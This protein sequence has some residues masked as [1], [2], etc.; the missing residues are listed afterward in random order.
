MGIRKFLIRSHPQSH[1]TVTILIAIS[2]SFS[3]LERADRHLRIFFHFLESSEPG[4]VYCALFGKKSC[5]WKITSAYHF[6]QW[7]CSH[8]FYTLVGM[9]QFNGIFSEVARSQFWHFFNRGRRSLLSSSVEREMKKI[10]HLFHL[11]FLLNDQL[12]RRM[13][14]TLF[15]RR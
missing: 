4:H 8:R 11:K 10:K 2:S 13:K 6:L 14:E 15:L 5:S 9:I 7:C 12:S 1:T 3:S